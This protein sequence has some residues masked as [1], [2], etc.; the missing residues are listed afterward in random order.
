MIT[1]KEE[2]F[3]E[4][5]E[6][7]EPMFIKHWEELANNKEERPLDI[8]YIGYVKL[9]A[10]GYLRMFTVR[11]NSKLIGY[12]TWMIANNLH[13]QTW[14]HAV[15]DV[16]YLEPAYRKTGVAN[17]MFSD[18]EG[19]LKNIGVN[20]VSIQDKVNHSHS[21]FFSN[22]GFKLTEQNYEKVL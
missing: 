8:D 7:T 4:I 14:K 17:E 13:Y 15:C 22:M 5:L 6:E 2:K 19:R 18:I 9:N 10:E 21:K 16:Y 3:A 1:F 11:D 12:S 20:L